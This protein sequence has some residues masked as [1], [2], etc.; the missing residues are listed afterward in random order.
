MSV[1]TYH[2]PTSQLAPYIECYWMLTLPAGQSP[3]PQIM[4]AD[5][6]FEIMFNFGMG[7]R[8]V[9]ASGGDE[10]TITAQSFVLGGRT[11][12][13]NLDHLGSPQ[14]VVIRFRTG[15]LS[16]FTR[17]PLSELADLYVELDCIWD[18]RLVR[19]LEEQLFNA[20]TSA[21]QVAALEEALRR[22]LAP[23]LYFD[24][25]RYSIH[26]L[27][28]NQ[29]T[30]Q[31]LSLLQLADETNLSQKHFERLFSRHIGFRP[32]LVAR[33]ARFHKA[34]YTGMHHSENLSLSQLALH[35]GYY[36]Q[37][38]FGKDFKRFSGVAPGEFFSASHDY[39]RSGVPPKLVDSVQDG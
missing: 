21:E 10:C 29:Q 15:G 38:H 14:Y 36:D 37:A 39:V 4:T 30:Q 12:G 16:A 18:Q 2:Y 26:R 23:P 28:V 27:T 19:E 3:P 11:Q 8:R 34:L 22:L 13:Y 5:H 25:L 24:P 9:N 17:L 33:I 31:A 32:N 6:R 7:S 20:R 35:A 1:F